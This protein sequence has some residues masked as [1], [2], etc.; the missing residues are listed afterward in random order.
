MKKKSSRVWKVFGMLLLL[1]LL[2][3]ALLQTPAGKT[4]LAS[5]LSRVLSRSVDL[6]VK[7]GKISGWIPASVQIDHLEISD[8]ESLWL[9][10]N[11]LHVRWDI[12]ALLDRRIHIEQLG[13]ETITLHRFPRVG[14]KRKSR[15]QGDGYNI[16]SRSPVANE[17]ER[18]GFEL[19]LKTLSIR[20][21]KINEAVAG[22]PLEYAV[23]SDG[24][25]RLPSGQMTGELRVSGDAEGR[26]EF[27]EEKISLPRFL[28]RY[29]ET[30]AEGNLFV[31]FS[32]EPIDI[33]LN[34]DLANTAGNS[35]SIRVEAS[36]STSEKTAT[37][38]TLELRGLDLLELSVHGTVSPEHLNLSG[39][40]AEFDIKDLPISGTSNFTGRTGGTLSLT[41]SPAKPKIQAELDVMEFTSAADDLLDELPTLDFHISARLADQQLIVSS[42]VTNTITGQLTAG[43]QMPCPFSLKPFLFDP[44]PG[45]LQADLQAE[46]DLY[47]L[48]QLKL[49]TDQRIAGRLKTELAYDN[50]LTGYVQMEQGAYEH[51]RWGVV[52]RDVA[53]DLAATDDGLQVKTATATDGGDGRIALTGGVTSNRLALA[54]EMKK[55][56]I[57]RRDELEGVF[58]GRLKIEGLWIHPEVT[59]RVRVDRADILL[60]NLAPALPPLLTDYDASL[61]TNRIDMVEKRS[62]LPFDLDLELELADRVFV[63]ASMIDSVWGGKLQINTLPEGLSVRGI[64]EP[65]RGYVSFIGKKFRFTDGQIDMDGSIPAQPSLN[66]L[67][68]EYNRADFTAR[69]ILNG[70]LDN[71]DFRLE[72]IPPMPEDEV[73]SQVLFG[74]DS[75][76]ITPYQ[77]YQIA[78][79]ARQ[80]SGGLTGPGFMY[81]VRQ[82]VGVDTLE[83]REGAGEGE[84]SSVAAGKYFTPALYVEVNRSLDEKGGTGMTAEYEVS[85]HFSIESSTGPQMRPGIGINW[86]RDY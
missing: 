50:R 70:R 84:A 24:I 82:T 62:S 81:N 55:A 42:S 14:K 4:L 40:L 86:K 65:Q 64:I 60:D 38:Q 69:L 28:I 47:I 71:P 77:A 34:T 63:N 22:V 12:R 23:H 5:G 67:T 19:N 57:I 21:L 59:G 52:V 29:G 6:N 83:W 8:A 75:S 37:F 17:H 72:S 56:A 31:D 73:L 7:I 74:R 30:T 1:P 41:G 36:V 15:P 11:S 33:Q 79:A 58:S 35:G 16:C 45:E 51:F 85:K 76:S 2:L 49:L 68:A 43:L 25:H 54:L 20:Q 27:S 53:L 78:A 18:N 46:L 26:I 48:N 39:T 61:E 13:A 9:S 10:A 32:K 80:L 3:I 66:Q 44:A